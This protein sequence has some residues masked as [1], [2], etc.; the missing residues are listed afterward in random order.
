MLFTY[1]QES[2]GYFGIQALKPPN[3]VAD[4]AKPAVVTGNRK[5]NGKQ[6]VQKKVDCA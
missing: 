4:A 6:I 1:A 3:N 2:T 5:S